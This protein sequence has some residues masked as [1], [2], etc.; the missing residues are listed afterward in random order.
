MMRI[1][2]NSAISRRNFGRPNDCAFEAGA[3]EFVIDLDGS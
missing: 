2:S 1:V 3:P